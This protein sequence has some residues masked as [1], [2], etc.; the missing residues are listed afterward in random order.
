MNNFYIYRFEDSKRSQFLAW[1]KDNTFH[2][3]DFDIMRRVNENVLARRTLSQPHYRNRYFQNLI[4]A[5]IRRWSRT[6]KEDNANN[7]P[8]WLER[9]VRRQRRSAA[10]RADTF[11]PFG[12]T[13]SNRRWRTC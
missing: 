1:D 4:D 9:E 2:S 10:G 13:I 6:A 8:G 3:L 5:A 7:R 12:T 11:K